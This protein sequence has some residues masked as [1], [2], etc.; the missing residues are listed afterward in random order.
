MRVFIAA[1]ALAALAACAST[2]T[3]APASAPGGAGY[4]ET[5]IESNRY[6]VTYRARG[7]AEASVLSDYALLRAAELTI[8][9]GGEWFWVDRRTMDEANARSGPS[10]GV[11]V[12]GGSWGG[13]G[14]GS[15]GVG[16]NI[17]L[18]G[19]G[20]QRAGAVTLE[21]RVGEGAKPDSADAYDARSTAQAL[22]ARLPAGGA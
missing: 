12:G 22:R 20:G 10:V 21:I 4:S 11:G 13:R 5:Q 2:P 1:F 9:R 14:G 6:F 8:E 18:G 3:Y 7:A 16:I 17:P 15:V 19:G